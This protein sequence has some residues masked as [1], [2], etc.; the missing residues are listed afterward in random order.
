MIRKKS[1]RNKDPVDIINRILNRVS[2]YKNIERVLIELVDP[3]SLADFVVDI[4]YA[5][6]KAISY[7]SRG[8]LLR[9]IV[10]LLKY[11]EKNPPY[12]LK[13]CKKLILAAKSE[14]TSLRKQE[15]LRHKTLMR[16]YL[17]GIVMGISVGALLG[18]FML[19]PLNQLFGRQFVYIDI[20]FM[21]LIVFLS[22]TISLLKMES[23]LNILIYTTKTE[24]K[25]IFRPLIAA[26]ISF[27]LSFSASFMLIH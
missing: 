19:V 8:Y 13:L 22:L 11:C 24:D 15:E 4:D 5:W 14:Y 27:L 18:T 12:I 16:L 7:F 2:Q 3:I 17:F 9:E 23:I 1:G 6:R 20:A 25:A 10:M 26:V 21:A